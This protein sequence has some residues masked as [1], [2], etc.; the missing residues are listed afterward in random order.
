MRFLSR[1]DRRAFAAALGGLIMS[2]SSDGNAQ[3]D[4][5]RAL[6]DAAASARVEGLK[7]LLANPAARGAID[8]PDRSG[9][10]ALLL[11]VEQGGDEA[12]IAL[13]G[14][15][16]D[17]NAQASNRDTPWLLAGADGQVAML[18]AMLATGRVDYAKRN[19]YGGNALI[20]A[21]HHGHVAAVR[22]LLAES[23]ID[24][25]QVND[26]GWTALLEAIIL[27]DG[28]PVHAEIVRLLV[29]HGAKLDLA[30]RQGI[31]PLT[32]ARQRRQSAITA[33]LEKAGA[34]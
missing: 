10:T 5:G 15:G 8:A 28:G 19:R 20:P 3:Q 27:G 9:K 4:F 11:A 1:F 21:A 7:H 24:V 31:T 30:D 29:A 13:I 32:H 14:A 12:A 23:K 34:R 26:L 33:I 22:F 17:I 25:D 16:A 2:G 18:R 6:R